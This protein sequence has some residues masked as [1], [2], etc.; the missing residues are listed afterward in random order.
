MLFIVL[1]FIGKCQHY[2]HFTG[3]E[4]EGGGGEIDLPKASQLLS[5]GALIGT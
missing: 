3:D 5:G 2:P 1:L 4:T